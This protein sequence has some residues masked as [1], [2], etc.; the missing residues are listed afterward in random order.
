M[1]SEI[2]GLSLESGTH[3]QQLIAYFLQRLASRSYHVKLKVLRLLLHCIRDGHCEFRQGLRKRS[4]R[5][6]DAAGYHGPPDVMHGNAPYISVRKA[7][8]DVL[9]QLFNTDVIE[10][11]TQRK[12]VPDKPERLHGMGTSGATGKYEGFGNAPMLP[13]KSIGDLVMSGL[14]DLKD[15]LV[16][17]PESDN[18]LL[19]DGLEGKFGLY[20]PAHLPTEA[21]TMDS[22]PRCSQGQVRM[23]SPPRCRE[24][25]IPGK[26]GGGWADSDD[27]E[28]GEGAP[29]GMKSS[30]TPISANL[31]SPRSE[32]ELTKFNWS[33]EEQLVKRHLDITKSGKMITRTEVED[34]VQQV[35]YLNVIKIV[36]LLRDH[37][38]DCS[39][40]NE[41]LLAMMLAM[42]ALLR[43]G[44]AS[45]GL[46]SSTL[47]SS[48][49]VLSQRTTDDQV[50]YKALKI[51]L[52]MERLSDVNRSSRMP[53]K[54]STAKPLFAN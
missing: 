41:S 17:A 31:L 18:A 27:G 48:L 21:I 6:K 39:S 28:E 43:S 19:R 32:E 10:A 44:V 54:S 35:L 29:E 49:D 30:D 25:R 11:E 46:L 12:P 22:G 13:E 51:M 5:I 14:I 36:E 26:P 9:E 16:G 47:T 40:S 52:I 8:E 7:A 20:S 50:K 38:E 1:I 37:V 3:C 34:F 33:E 15:K 4:Q 45:V 23:E 24:V 42:E 2:I 53:T